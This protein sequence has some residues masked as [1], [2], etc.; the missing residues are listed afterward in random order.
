MFLLANDTINWQSVYM[1]GYQAHWELAT[2]GKE[3][4]KSVFNVTERVYS[5]YQAC[6]EGGRE[7]WSQVQR[8][9]DLFDGVTIGAPALRYGQQQV[10]HL[11]ASVTEQT[12]GYYPP[13]CE[14]E[15]IVNLTIAFCDPLDGLT[16]GIVSRSDLC[17][18]NFNVTDIIGEPYYCAASDG[19]STGAL[20]RR[21]VGGSSSAPEQNGTVSAEGA[22]LAQTLWD[23][24]HDSEGKRVY[25][26][27]QP[28]ADFGDASTTYNSDTAEWEVSISDLGGQW[29][30]EFLQLKDVDNLSTLDNVTY[31]TLKEWMIFGMQKYGDSLQTTQPDVS[32]F[33][34]AGGKVIHVHGEQDPSIPTASSVHYYESVRSVMFP[35]MTFNA[36][37]E[38]M[39]DFYRMFLVPGGAHCGVN[40]DQP[41]GG[42]PATTLQTVI[43]W[44]ENGVAPSFLNN[45]GTTT[46]ELCKWP[47]RPL[48]AN[49][50]TTLDCVYDQASWDSWIYEFDAYSTVLY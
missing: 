5:Y 20:G 36:S 29:V 32:A 11:T 25:I 18:I 40:T 34:N 8:F 38:A 26:Y 22:A 35:N 3:F 10:N 30:G 13:T 41:N 31:D 14:L 15:K 45:T 7:G 24:L 50:G 19:S 12:L 48:Y 28:G 6:S 39:D 16:D 21:Q 9:A 23:G 49:N 4:T 17:K 43:E 46:P 1:M 47:L 2:L 42:W 37:T 44:V 27:Y 33:A